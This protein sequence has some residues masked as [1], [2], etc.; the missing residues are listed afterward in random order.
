MLR[1]FLR[2]KDKL[3]NDLDVS[4]F[5]LTLFGANCEPGYPARSTSGF[6]FCP[7][8]IYSGSKTEAL[9][10]IHCLML[11]HLSKQ[12]SIR[13]YVVPN[14]HFRSGQSERQTDS[15]T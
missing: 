1:F 5:L 13:R 4:I 15:G 3:G 2:Y 11:L 6:Q 9:K 12:G 14:Q 7:L 8:N 10:Q